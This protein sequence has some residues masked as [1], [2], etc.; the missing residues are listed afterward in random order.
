MKKITRIFLASLLFCLPYAARAQAISLQY[1]ENDSLCVHQSISPWMPITSGN[2]TSF[3]VAPPLPAGISLNPATGAITGTPTVL[4]AFG[5]YQITATGPGSSAQYTL[6][7]G[8]PT[9]QGPGT[10]W[11]PPPSYFNYPP[12]LSMCIGGSVDIEPANGGSFPGIT[13]APALPAGL[14]LAFIEGILTGTAQGPAS[15]G[16][17]VF[18]GF[19][20]VITA[21][22][23]DTMFI[24]IQ[25][26]AAA[27]P[28]QTTYPKRDT[29]CTG[30]SASVTAPVTVLNGP[31]TYCVSNGLPSGMFMS[32]PPACHIQG[33]PTT[34]GTYLS[35]V[36]TGNGNGF[37]WDTL[38]IQVVSCGSV[39]V[40]Y[41]PGDTVCV[42]DQV[43]FAPTAGGSNHDFRVSPALPPG[44]TMN[45][46]TGV[47]SGVPVNQGSTVQY[48]VTDGV[49]GPVLSTFIMLVG[50]PGFCP[51]TGIRSARRAPDASF[52]I[53]SGSV[54]RYR[55]REKTSVEIHLT[56]LQGRV[57]SHLWMPG[58]PAGSHALKLPVHGIPEGVYVLRLQTGDGARR[59]AKLVVGP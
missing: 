13:V 55:L 15:S 11:T 57:V 51:A 2:I 35:T 12:S 4:T 5:N 33:P 26:C 52:E 19:D 37:D 6:Y 21:T 14:N 30:D 17:Y 24:S 32:P 20:T 43:L 31:L 53:A 28:P 7:T 10:P 9:C 49:G 8:V 38:S 41:P 16:L 18:S 44:L 3:S 22:Y 1:P 25:N 59:S 29:V 36:V 46:S 34:P 23:R 48:T 40:Q 54:L 58:Q 42:G 47:I 50:P 27:I 45:S 56:D 39:P